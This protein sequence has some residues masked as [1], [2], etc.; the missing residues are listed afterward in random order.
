[1]TDKRKTYEEEFDAELSQWDLE[2]V[3]LKDK[4]VKADNEVK[5][6]CQKAIEVLDQKQKE[7][8]AK[9]LELKAAGGE[10]WE[11]L[12]AAMEIARMDL[13]IAFCSVA[14]KLEAENIRKM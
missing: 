5:I 12:K 14:A 1:V 7:A 13:K 8:K 3:M 10:A 11:D 9:L 4:A 6:A 2:L